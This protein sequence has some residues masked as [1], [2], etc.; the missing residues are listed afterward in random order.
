MGAESKPVERHQNIWPRVADVC[1]K[2][3]A[4]TGIDPLYVYLGTAEYA[5]LCEETGLDPA[6]C[7]RGIRSGRLTILCVNHISH[8]RV[9]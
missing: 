6:I 9:S 4:D 7:G 1:G 8:M 2:Y 5:A 3:Y